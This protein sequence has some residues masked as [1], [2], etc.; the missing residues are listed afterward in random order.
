MSFSCRYALE[1]AAHW[2][3]DHDEYLK[4]PYA[5]NLGAL[6]H[7]PSFKENMPPS[8][9]PKVKS[10]IKRETLPHTAVASQKLLMHCNA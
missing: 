7:E 4:K 8:L 6:I 9:F 3:Y 1:R 10:F 2:L 5:D